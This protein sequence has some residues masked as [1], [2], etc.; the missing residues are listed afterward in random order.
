MTAQRPTVSL[1]VQRLAH[2]KDL[3][4]PSYGTDGAA[5]MDLFAAVSDPVVIAPGDRAVI[6]TGLIVAIEPGFEGQVR[7]R[8]GRARRE[9]LALVNAPGT[10]DD[11]YRGEVQVLVINLGRDPITIARGDRFAQLVICPVFRALITEVDAIEDTSRGAG[12]FGS[13][14]R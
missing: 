6:P 14:G 5:G 9:G 10:I 2:S 13:T 7:A 3:P 8:S 1:R 4:L 11:D 12:G